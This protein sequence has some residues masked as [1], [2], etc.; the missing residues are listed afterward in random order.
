MTPCTFKIIH[1][2]AIVVVVVL[3]PSLRQLRRCSLTKVTKPKPRSRLRPSNLCRAQNRRDASSSR[4]K[5]APHARWLPTPCRSL[6]RANPASRTDSVA[7]STAMTSRPRPVSSSGLEPLSSTPR[8][9]VSV[10]SLPPRA[11]VHNV[12]SGA[13]ALRHRLDRISV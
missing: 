9:E 5:R 13:R 12:L 2:I 6:S 3:G 11:R 1:V 4:K 10:T 7:R 8:K